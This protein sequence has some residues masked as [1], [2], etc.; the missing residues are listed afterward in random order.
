M[1]VAAREDLI[2]TWGSNLAS[3]LIV[4]TP[5]PGK[6]RIQTITSTHKFDKQKQKHQKAEKV[7]E[8]V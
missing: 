2:A 1:A 4:L 6:K 3:S 7:D 8:R 5:K